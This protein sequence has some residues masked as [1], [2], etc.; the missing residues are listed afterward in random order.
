MNKTASFVAAVVDRTLE[1]HE[2]KGCAFREDVKSETLRR[3]A[4]ERASEM[5]DEQ[6]KNWL[7]QT[8]L[9]YETYCPHEGIDR[10]WRA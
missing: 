10:R 2:E 9:E 5:T 3:F 1:L 8:L 7:A 4:R 6:F